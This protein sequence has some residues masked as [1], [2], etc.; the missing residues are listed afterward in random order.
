M[1]IHLTKDQLRQALGELNHYLAEKNLTG[2]ICICGGA[3]MVLAFNARL[4]TKDVDAIFEPPTTI[5]K[6]AEAV[7]RKLSLPADWLNDGVKGFLSA[8][9]KLTEKDMYQH[10]HL[11]VV[12]PTAEYLLAMKC[13]ASRQVGYDTPGDKRDIAFLCER[14]K[15]KTAEDALKIVEEYYPASQ[16]QPKTQFMLQEVFHEKN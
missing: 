3:A 1:T 2:E 9:S 14:L 11:R 6:A 13:M 5:R 10:S 4:T 16:I 7:A 15:L 12:R 8:K